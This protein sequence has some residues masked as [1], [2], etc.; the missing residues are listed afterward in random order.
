MRITETSTDSLNSIAPIMLPDNAS[1]STDIVQDAL[2]SKRFINYTHPLFDPDD[3]HNSISDPSIT[4]I[5]TAPLTFISATFQ[6][7]KSA[8]TLD[9]RGMTQAVTNM[10]QSPLALGAAITQSLQ[11]AVTIDLITN[12]ALT[13]LIPA[14]AA[15][16]IIYLLIQTAYEARELHNNLALNK[17]LD[18]KLYQE[19]DKL[20]VKDDLTHNDL[21]QFL[22]KNRTKLAACLEETDQIQESAN[23]QNLV[24]KWKREFLKGKLTK[25]NDKYAGLT[26]KQITKIRTHYDE[27]AAELSDDQLITLQ[28]TTLERIQET[29]KANS[30]GLERRVR[31]WMAR[32]FFNRIESDL[33]TLKTGEIAAAQDLYLNLVSQ[34]EKMRIFH[35]ASLV[36]LVA[37]T[38]FVALTFAHLP[39]MATFALAAIQT[40]YFFVRN[41]LAYGWLDE[42]GNHFKFKH[43]FPN[44]ARRLYTKY[45]GDNNRPLNITEDDVVNEGVR[46]AMIEG[47]KLYDAEQNAA[48]VN[49]D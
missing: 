36:M 33:E 8:A 5:I 32:E 24:T 39:T 4:H 7:I 3:L 13:A 31:P 25:I 45:I 9:K 43:T 17:T 22:Q 29:R 6:L 26:D 41:S 21:N 34:A 28:A 40:S 15:L 1:A 44:W 18:I 47:Q 46:A 42:R 19:L 12:I 30:E 10:I 38:V 48:A 49:E 37:T 11:F 2:D 27:K 16:G 35:I 23:I 14:S 20:S